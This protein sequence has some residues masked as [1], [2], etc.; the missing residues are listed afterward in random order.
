MDIICNYNGIKDLADTGFHHI[1]LDLSSFCSLWEL[2]NYGKTAPKAKETK[3]AEILI[4]EH[5]SELY[6][7]IRSL[8]KQCGKA[9]LHMPIA[10]APYVL[11]STE[12]TAPDDLLFR[13][14]W[15]S[16]GCCGKAGARFII[17]RP[18]PAG[19][20][21]DEAW[22]R[23]RE[24]YLRLAKAAKEYHVMILLQNQCRDLNGHLIRGL[25]ADAEE[26]ALWVDRLNEETGEERFGFCMDVGV[27]SLCG[28]NMHDFILKLGS[29]LKAV[30]LR[31]GEGSR[32]GSL[33]PFTVAKQGQS[34][35]DWLNLIRGLRETGFDGQLVMD[36][37]DTISAFPAFLRGELIRLA[38]KT[39]DY[40]QW[41]IEIE[42]VLKKHSSI[43]LFGAGNMCRNYMKCY[44]EKYPP[45]FTCDNNRGIWGTEF[46]GLKVEPPERLKELPKDC[47]VLICNIYYKEIREQLLAMGVENPIEYFNDE[48]M[49]SYYF[50]RLEMSRIE[51]T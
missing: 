10:Q 4:S 46:C 38:R 44:G 16:I 39:A 37:R 20:G 27:S 29:R 12:R 1:L 15:E 30:I 49:P 3:Q 8:L 17:I 18:L 43:V 14:A 42:R 31:D 21:Y 5:P 9:G 41:Q 51:F 6:N 33:L 47:A 32:E 35:T 23:N 26:A 19:A 22:E 24:F 48:Y 28:Q 45:L 11:E 13:L 50:D 2:E 7:R 40:F 36:F 34:R 25:C